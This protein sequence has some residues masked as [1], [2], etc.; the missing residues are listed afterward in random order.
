MFMAQPKRLFEVPFVY[1]HPC[2]TKCSQIIFMALLLRMIVR[3][4]RCVKIHSR[5]SF[6][7]SQ[8]SLTQLPNV[9]PFQQRIPKRINGVIQVECIDVHDNVLHRIVD[10]RLLRRLTNG[11]HPL[12]TG[13]T[14]RGAKPQGWPPYYFVTAITVRSR[15]FSRIVRCVSFSATK[16]RSIARFSMPF[17]R[18]PFPGIVASSPGARIA[19]K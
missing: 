17:E 14:E 7:I 18:P 2:C 6:A 12:C 19:L 3:P 4:N 15:R 1:S 5:Q 16:S 11:I 10:I 9:Q 8:L 13:A